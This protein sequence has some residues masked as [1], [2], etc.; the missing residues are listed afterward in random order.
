[1]NINWAVPKVY[2]WFVENSI[3]L[4]SEL[5]CWLFPIILSTF[6]SW[7]F[8]FQH[9]RVVRSE[10]LQSTWRYLHLYE[11]WVYL[12]HWHWNS[13]TADFANLAQ[14]PKWDLI[15]FS[16]SSVPTLNQVIGQAPLIKFM[17]SECRVP[18]LV[19]K[20]STKILKISFRSQLFGEEPPAV[21]EWGKV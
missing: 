10:L 11:L 9:A 3:L 19:L 2:G 12:K 16:H 14:F 5:D 15:C 18:Q 20:Q 6:S 4:G 7:C 8:F 21:Q 1:M 13:K 17:I